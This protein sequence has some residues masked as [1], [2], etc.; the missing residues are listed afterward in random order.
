MYLASILIAVALLGT[1]ARGEAPPRLKIG[2]PAPPLRTGAWI[3]GERITRL[4]PGKAYLVDFWATWCAPCM[5]SVPHLN[6]LHE[7]FK[8]RGLVVIG[9]NVSER[10][11]AKV[12]TA[13]SKAKMAYRIAL[14]DIRDSKDGR[15]SETW[16]QPTGI[17]WLPLAILVDP[18]GRV[19]WIGSP[20]G[21]TSNLIEEVLTGRFDLV[22][23]ARR[24]EA[25]RANQ[26]KSER[27]QKALGDKKVSEAETA[28]SDL[29]MSTPPED[30]ADLDFERLGLSLLKRDSARIVELAGRLREAYRENSAWMHSVA[31]MLVAT[32]GLDDQGLAAA[33]DLAE[34]A[35][36]AASGVDP[37]YLDTLA[38]V[39]FLRGR[40]EKAIATQER[41]V[42][43][44]DG[45]LRVALEQTLE[46]Y[47]TGNLRT[48]V[49]P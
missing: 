17:P 13:V 44:A 45:P 24:Y 34:A 16:Q 40:K 35:S 2:D 42:K 20:D 21:I 3:Q 30:L 15:M 29:E 36:A 25:Q 8:D 14:D 22:K 28:L 43:C 41:A 33:E 47:R 32:E 27:F 26:A 48:V 5:A 11:L 31:S 23:A 49:R 39:Q 19:A 7:A 18:N 38:R 10:N 37:Q 6:A 46:R 4:E 12:P 1:T 9:Q